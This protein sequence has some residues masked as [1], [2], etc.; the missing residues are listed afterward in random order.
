MGDEGVGVHAIETLARESWPAEVTLLDGG[1][2]SFQLLSS[3]RDHDRVILID[4]SMDGHPPGT[5]RVLHPKYA[6][7]FP[8]SLTAHDIGLRDLIET[9]ALIQGLPPIALVTVSIREIRPM[10]MTLSD[11]VQVAI[12][13]ISRCVRRLLAGRGEEVVRA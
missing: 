6:S 10:T 9:A 13:Q 12:P 7:D 5:V 2:G 1:T 3:L 8:R 11:A 4:A